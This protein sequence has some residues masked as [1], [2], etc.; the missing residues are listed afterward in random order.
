LAINRDKPDR[1][2]ADIARSVDFYNQWFMKFA[3]A[4]YRKERITATKAVEDALRW[5]KNLTNVGADLLRTYPGILPALRMCTCPPIARDRLIGLSGVRRGLV[6][7][8]EKSQKLPRNANATA[9][10][11]E[12]EKI[13]AIFEKMAD[14][15]IFTWL[16]SHTEPKPS[17]VHRAATIVADRLCGSAADPIIRNAQEARQLHVLGVWLKRRGY[18]PL[19]AKHGLKF[20]AMPSGTYAFRL[21]VPVRLGNTGKTINIPIDAIVMPKRAT[22]RELPILIEAKSAGDFT[23][24]NKRR[25]EE[26][27][28]VGQ[29]RETYGESLKFVLLLCGY[30]DSGYLGYEAA[31]GIDWVWEHRLDDLA[32]FKL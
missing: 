19:P 31:D 2:K 29:L 14:P 11:K 15:D 1:W 8:M 12:L 6:G 24:V 22:R 20:D 3:P 30:F 17:E 16:Q 13:G 5:T 26:A 28:K 18:K 32:D 4:A 25:K 7:L 10:G 23:N 27:K 9:L 21:N